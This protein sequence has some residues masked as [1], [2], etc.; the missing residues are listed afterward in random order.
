MLRT[1]DRR[2]QRKKHA[3]NLVSLHLV[4]ARERREPRQAAVVQDEHGGDV[5]NDDHE[6]MTERRGS[7]LSTDRSRGSSGERPLARAAKMPRVL[8]DQKSIVLAR[9]GKSISSR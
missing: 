7:S 4:L 1:K 3:T 9:L 8:N 6:M 2:R 5:D